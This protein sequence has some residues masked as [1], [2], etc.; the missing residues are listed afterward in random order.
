V[1]PE[2][3]LAEAEIEG[4]S[5]E[6]NAALGLQ[7]R[8]ELSRRG[9]VNRIERARIAGE[10]ATRFATR[11]GG[12]GM[13]VAG[14]SGGNQQRFIAAR[15]LAL[16]PRLIVAF[17]PARGLDLHGARAVFDGIREE[18]DA[19]AGALIVSFDLDELLDNCDRIVTL[20]NGR[21]AAPPPGSE[22]DRDLIGRL[23]VGA[24]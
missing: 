20:F 4:W 2:D 10:I 12:L 1:L 8:P 18:C 21:L 23:M 3:R 24:A 11:H 6:L 9:A 19:G 16:R 17:Q 14:L 22:R 7:R 13:P 15:T 5:L